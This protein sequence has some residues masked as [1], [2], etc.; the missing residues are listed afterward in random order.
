MLN[1]ITVGVNRSWN[2]T[3][4]CVSQ[5]CCFETWN[6]EWMMHLYSALLCI[7]IHPKRFTIMWGSLLNHHQWAAGDE[8]SPSSC[9][10]T[11]EVLDWGSWSDNEKWLLKNTAGMNIKKKHVW[12]FSTQIISGLKPLDS[13]A[14]DIQIS[15]WSWVFHSWF[16]KK[17][18]GKKIYKCIYS[19]FL[20]C[21]MGILENG[22]IWFFRNNFA[23][24]V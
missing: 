5:A 18:K 22:F 14:T 23:W 10:S 24:I 21:G 19:A 12:S 2:F 20:V 9:C 3:T 1:K 17:K 7:A 11:E 16:T 8:L 4:K 6:N 13:H 15:S